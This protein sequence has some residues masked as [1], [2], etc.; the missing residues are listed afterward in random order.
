MLIRLLRKDDVVGYEVSSYGNRLA[1]A[2]EKEV[3]C[4]AVPLN[5]GDL[6]IIWKSRKK[7]EKE[8]AL[9]LAKYLRDTPEE[10]CVVPLVS[11]REEGLRADIWMAEFVKR[12]RVAAINRLHGLYGQVG[13]IDVTKKEREGRK[14]RHGELG[15]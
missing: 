15:L 2:L 12:E 8:D 5:A 11:E 9:K 7:R 4:Q 6:R 1:R 3:G 13:I 14:G 10:G